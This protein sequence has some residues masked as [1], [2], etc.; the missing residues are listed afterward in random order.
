MI[1]RLVSEQRVKLARRYDNEDITGNEEDVKEYI[2]LRKYNKFK[3]N[4]AGTLGDICGYWTTFC[5]TKSQLNEFDREISGLIE[6]AM[7]GLSS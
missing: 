6:S 3:N 1:G 7:K 4:L 2:L 5:W